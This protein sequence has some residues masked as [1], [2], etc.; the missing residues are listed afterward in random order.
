M[1]NK[2]NIVYL[3]KSQVIVLYY[4]CKEGATHAEIAEKIGRDVKTVQYHMTNIYM[5][6]EIRK[7]GKSKE[8]MEAEL[9]S[10]IAPV[11]R[12][13]FPTFDDVKTWVP[14]VRDRGQEEK[15]DP[16]E[17][18]D[19]PPPYTLP[20]SVEAILGKAENPP[21]PPEILQTPPPPRRRR[22]WWSILGW[23]ALGFLVAIL[24]GILFLVNRPSRS[25]MKADPTQ[26][27]LPSI[28]APTA[29]P[30]V[31]TE[32]P[33]T[34]FIP[35]T[36]TP[37]TTRIMVSDIDKMVL[38][39]ISAGEFKMGSSRADDPVA[40]DEEV[41]PHIVYL[42]EYWIDR[43]EVSNAQYAKCVSEG[44]CTKPA[45]NS[46]ST[47]TSYYDD[48]QYIDYPVI[49]VSWSQAAAY[50]DWAGRRLPTEA[51]WE[52]AARGPEGRIYPWGNTF[53]GTLLN[54]CDRNCRNSWKDDRFDD[55]YA[56][57]SPVGEYL[58][59]KS[60]YEVLDLSGN[61]YEW[62]EDWFSPYSPDPLENPTSPPFGQEKIIRGGSW[63]DDLL[64]V[65]SAI[66]SHL[67]G[68]SWMDFIGFRCALTKSDR[69]PVSP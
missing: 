9:N 56:D 1:A 7:P 57:T 6:L 4:K 64:H 60:M 19:E 38:V 37:P 43:T 67:N 54:Y 25:E 18:V 40:F 59:G 30:P 66:R 53:D 69:T 32:A 34:P 15:E 14:M 49:Y 31:P 10:E 50:C 8:A 24:L 46:S 26:P 61:V 65:R 13:M 58:D 23:T 29:L 55:G 62:V 3:T 17:D 48:S 36:N 52:K 42:D 35:S 44:A 28:S 68:D 20:R 5:V 63:G 41:P 12:E 16:A 33:P 27:S 22:N 47:R 51:E 39:A 21:S 11:I 45:N 2:D